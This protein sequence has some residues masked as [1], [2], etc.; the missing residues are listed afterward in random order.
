MIYD[1]NYNTNNSCIANDITQLKKIKANQNIKFSGT[2]YNFKYIETNF[3]DNKKIYDDIYK[4]FK[5]IKNNQIDIDKLKK[6]IQR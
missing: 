4:F 5:S 2:E 3:N 1:K 6:I